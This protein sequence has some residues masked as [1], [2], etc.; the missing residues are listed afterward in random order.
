MNR[1]SLPVAAALAATAALLLTA[2]GSGDS[3]KD[4][5]KIAGADQG[6]PTKAP[7]SATTDPG[8]PDLSLPSDVTETFEGWKTGDKTKDAVLADAGHAQTAVTHAVVKGDPEDTALTFY[9]AGTALAGSQDWVKTIVDSGSTFT[10]AVRYYAPRIVVADQ[11]TAAVTYCSDESKAF[12]K[13][14]KTNKVDKTPVT[15]DAYVLYSTRLEKNA[16]GVWQTTKLQSERGN[17]TCTP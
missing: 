3:P 14:R 9:Q 7:P 4:N 13:N 15:N 1:R 17:K 10:G 8:R 12:N 6:E 2:C 16:Q 5:D 11:D